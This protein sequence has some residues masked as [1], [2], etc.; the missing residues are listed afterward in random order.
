LRLLDEALRMA[1]AHGDAQEQMRGYWN[2]FANTFC[3]A[4]W[5]DTLVRFHDAA[6]ALRRLGQGHLVPALQVNAA[7]CLHRLGRWDEAE[8]M[9]QDARLHQR[10]GEDP[11]RLAELDLARCDFAVARDY[12]ER[13]RAARRTG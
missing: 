13:Q 11:V 4:R 2:L 1:E 5:E 8:R 10:A 12:L 6:G 7:D 9:V 3:A